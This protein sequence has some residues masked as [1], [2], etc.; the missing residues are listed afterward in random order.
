MKNIPLFALNFIRNPL[1]NASIVPSSGAASRAM[2]EDIDF[3]SINTI[4][5]LGPGTGVFTAEIVKRSKPD[6]KI[7]LIEIEPSYVRSLQKKFGNRIIV[8]HASAHLLDSVLKKHG[9]EQ[10]DL[11]VSGLPFLAGAVGQGLLDSIKKHTGGKTIFR[12]FTYVPPIMKR[13]Y[14]DLPI[15]KISFVSKNI[16]PMW[17]YGIN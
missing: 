9:I 17:I 16:P 3:S 8:E 5:E 1:R 13:I 2:L 10:L 14:K 11:I 12:F 15:R 6:A 4:V 7:L